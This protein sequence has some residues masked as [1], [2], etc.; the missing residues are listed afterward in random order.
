V[1]E[2]VLV[3]VDDEAV[4][5]E[6]FGAYAGVV[7]TLEVVAIVVGV[8]TQDL[9]EGAVFVR[10]DGELATA[11]F[12]G[13]SDPDGGAYARKERVED[14]AAIPTTPS[15]VLR[16]KICASARSKSPSSKPES[17]G[18]T[19]PTA[20][21]RALT[22]DASRKPKAPRRMAS[23]TAIAELPR[24]GNRRSLLKSLFPL[25]APASAS[26]ILLQARAIRESRPLSARH[27]YPTAI[28]RECAW[29]LTQR[30]PDLMRPGRRISRS[31][32]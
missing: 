10:V 22:G 13:N 1:V 12:D 26:P 4:C 16:G 6:A 25:L 31:F 11:F 14:E 30:R 7:G 9:R 19:M 27:S 29:R 15:V 3:V 23:I 2:D 5:A 17:F 20:K 18:S 21:I 8:V 24:S 28:T 32:C